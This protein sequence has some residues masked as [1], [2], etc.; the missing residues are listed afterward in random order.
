[1]AIVINKKN[2]AELLSAT[3]EKVIG[4]TGLNYFDSD[5]KTKA[6]VNALT[7]EQI[8]LQKELDSVIRNLQLETV[9]GEALTRYGLS[10]GVEPIDPTFA[11]VTS[12]EL[13]VAFYTSTG[14]TF[15]SINS[16]NPIT[17]AAGSVIYS[18]P[19][20]NESGALIEYVTEN[21]ITL[22]AANTIQYISCRAKLS[23][24]ISNVGSGVLLN[25]NVSNYTDSGNSSL[26]VVNFYPILNGRDKEPEDNYKFRI[27]QKYNSLIQNSEA[28][29]KL[30]TLTIPGVINIKAVPGLFGIGTVGV[31]V[32]SSD[33]ESNESLIEAVQ[34]RL[35]VFQGVAGQMIAIPAS[36]V[37][38]NLTLKAK[39]IKDL[40]LVDK[41]LLEVDIR[42][43]ID[44]YFKNIGLGGA[45]NINDLVELIKAK[46][47]GSLKFTNLNNSFFQT[48][49]INRDFTTN[50]N[51][52]VQY[53]RNPVYQL[54]VD[55]FAYLG[56]SFELEIENLSDV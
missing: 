4:R 6:L 24:S 10:M 29:I 13:N 36:K 42:R 31:V 30:N 8:F 22:I 45:V 2:P 51:T 20:N 49:N 27:A 28:K 39:A 9:T 46:H 34:R 40:T 18:N 17:I 53:L 35:D 21:P 23:G 16:S 50:F 47:K 1:M 55:E 14:G 37:T 56:N 25:H 33:F 38:F 43:I 11:T 19:N 12:N 3:K 44:S 7:E 48:I 15:G 5:S 26:K 52:Q 41:S 54:E 32:L